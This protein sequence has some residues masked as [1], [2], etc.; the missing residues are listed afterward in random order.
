MEQKECD[1]NDKKYLANPDDYECNKK[2][3]RWN[4][5]KKKPNKKDNPDLN[6]IHPVTGKSYKKTGKKGKEILAIQQEQEFEY[7]QNVPQEI[8]N[9]SINQPM[10][11]I[12]E[13]VKK[14]NLNV[15]DK[16]KANLIRKMKNVYR[17]RPNIEDSTPVEKEQSFDKMI[18]EKPKIKQD[19][20]EDSISSDASSS[21]SWFS[22]QRKSSSEKKPPTK[23]KSENSSSIS[24]DDSFFDTPKK[25]SNEKKTTDLKN[26][27]QLLFGKKTSSSTK[28]SSEETAKVSSEQKVPS[29]FI[30]S[31]SEQPSK[32]TGK[33]K[34]SS[35]KSNRLDSSSS[36]LASLTKKPRG[37]TDFSISQEEEDSFFQK[38]PKRKRL[39]YL[40]ESQSSEQEQETQQSSEQ[41]TQLNSIQIAKA[42]SCESHTFN[43]KNWTIVNM[44]PDNHCGFHSIIYGLRSSRIQIDP[45][46]LNVNDTDKNLVL[47]LRFMLI[48]HYQK[49]LNEKY[50]TIINDP[51]YWLEDED[52]SFFAEEFKICFCIYDKAADNER[53]KIYD[54]DLG[55]QRLAT[56]EERRA[57]RETLNVFT[58]IT[59]FGESC[60]VFIYL[61][62]TGNHYDVMFPKNY[63]YNTEAKVPKK[64]K[65]SNKDIIHYLLDNG[66]EISEE[67]D[68]EQTSWQSSSSSNSSSTDK[69]QKEKSISSLSESQEIISDIQSQEE[70]LLSGNVHRNVI[71]NIKKS[72]NIH[73]ETYTQLSNNEV[74]KIIKKTIHEKHF[75]EWLK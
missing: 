4:K 50:E 70:S 31:S 38:K 28:S 9:L 42:I 68:L 47:K 15:R 45:N 27:N 65:I 34:K 53:N 37:K 64:I 66:F 14:L 3:G 11:E 43:K 21:N 2:T 24:D 19:V 72:Q 13:I 59:P 75:P 35:S 5:K 33:K 60:N 62:Q 57:L 12:R 74:R 20:Q 71:T 73:Y 29:D 6:V 49:N 40:S 39:S 26:F 17:K 56:K 51:D 41:Q 18:R 52:L 55:R 48:Q 8:L 63:E 46:M 22:N 25:Q 1:K 58:N 61:Y 54:P 69:S 7:V 10:K 67:Q 23:S 30:P 16:V 36:Q 32:S 44:P